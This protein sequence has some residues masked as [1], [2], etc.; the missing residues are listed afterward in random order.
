MKQSG[1]IKKTPADE[2]QALRKRIAVLENSEN[3]YQR[4]E[5]GLRA[6]EAKYKMLL[7]NMRDGVYRSTADGKFI[8][9]NQSMVRIF[10]YASQEELLAADIA[11]DIYLSPDERDRVHPSGVEVHL[12][13]Y[14]LKRKDGSG[15][16]VE[17]NCHFIRDQ[18]GRIMFHEGVLRDI[19]E[20]RK[21][22][23]K[24]RESEEQYRKLV[25][26]SP[27]GICI[28]NKGKVTYV[29][30]T[31]VILL[32]ANDAS[33]LTGKR[34]IDFVHSD[35]REPG[36]EQN[37]R[38]FKSCPGVHPIEQKFVRLDGTIVDVD[39]TTT[40]IP[41]QDRSAVQVVFR[42]ITER[43]RSEEN[44][45]EEKARLLYILENAPY[46]IILVAADGRYLFVN[47][48]FTSI[49]GYTLKDVPNG[50]EWFNRAYPDPRYRKNVIDNWKRNIKH[51]NTAKQKF[52]VVCKNGTKREIEFNSTF[53]GDG[54]IV[55]MFQNASHGQ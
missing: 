54:R 41:Y 1:K 12:A 20:R 8:E 50:R 39:V 4:A 18:Q 55:V 37:R 25:E 49:T 36:A 38:G 7:E 5:Q 24:L 53:L 9:I 43:K 52:S 51:D 3:E 48:V 6:S 47:Q 15:I 23:E 30:P 19:T 33:Q 22:E 14:Q 10:G 16:W 32:G 44:I 45:Q 21:A 40:T 26:K 35:G 2:L 42:D 34:F 31:G 28:H 17:D 46:G 27:D 13:E 29:N 11:N